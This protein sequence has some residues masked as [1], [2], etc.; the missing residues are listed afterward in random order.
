MRSTSPFARVVIVPPM[1]LDDTQPL[2]LQWQLMFLI[3]PV[4]P[5]VCVRHTRGCL[6]GCGAQDLLSVLSVL[7]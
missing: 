5:W 6:D 3:A 1:Q 7:C 4:P 2:H